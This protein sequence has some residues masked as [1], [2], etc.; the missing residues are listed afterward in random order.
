MSQA[1]GVGGADGSAAFLRWV[2]RDPSQP[3]GAG[4]RPSSR[5][6]T[7]ADSNLSEPVTL[8]FVRH[9]I[10]LPPFG[11]L[12]DPR[13]LVDIALATESHG[14]DG[15]YIWDHVL[16]PV[17]GEWA[18]ADPWVTLAAAATVTS[19]IRLG[20]MVTPLPRR[21]V[22]KLARETVTLDH[23]S[24][25]RLTLG[26]GI[27][28]D[29]GR[30]LSAF[31][32][33]T[34]AR[35]RGRVLDIGTR[36]LVD[37]W[38]GVTVNSTDDVVADGV[39]LTLGPVQRPRIPIWFGSVRPSGPP[40]ARAA[41]YDGLFPLNAD[42]DDIKHIFETVAKIRGDVEGFDVAVVARRDT[43]LGAFQAA[44]ATWAMHS[45][46]PGNR[47]DQVLRLIESGPIS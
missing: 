9:A 15:L 32:E 34:D 44:G 37:L 12:A 3:C 20:T 33:I 29:A 25:G 28:T 8:G 27:G 4:L 22:I 14:W 30:E 45:F 10:Y 40:V 1:G 43:D 6:V 16:S 41:K 26:L 13:A 38:S 19:R 7:I 21:R 39:R 35:Q 18:I 36:V 42:P 31:G 11:D 23:L 17:P 5:R 46:W 24:D 47:P 2:V